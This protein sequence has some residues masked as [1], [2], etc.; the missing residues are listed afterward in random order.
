MPKLGYYPPPYPEE[1]IQGS[2]SRL[3]AHLGI[4]G[5][6]QTEVLFQGQNLKVSIDTVYN[7]SHFIKLLPK[8]TF[9]NVEE[10]IFQ[11]SLFPFYAPFLP[12]ESAQD[13]LIWTQNNPDHER[14]WGISKLIRP[15]A[16]PSMMRYCPI[17]VQEHREEYGE[18][19]WHRLHQ[20]PG[21][22]ICLK[23]LVFL[24]NSIVPRAASLRNFV[25]PAAELVIDQNYNADSVQPS[26]KIHRIMLQ[27]V[28]DITWL[29]NQRNVYHEL[30]ELESRCRNLLTQSGYRGSR[31]IR[32][33]VSEMRSFVP[34]EIFIK[35]GIKT[36]A[37][38]DEVLYLFFNQ[39]GK[40]PKSPILFF[41]FMQF[42]D[43]S[44]ETFFSEKT[45]RFEPFG[46]GPWPCL[47]P[48]CPDYGL[49][50]IDEVFFRFERQ[51]KPGPTG[52][53]LC[54][55]GFM[56]NCETLPVFPFDRKL[57]RVVICGLKWEETLRY[58]WD[59]PEMSLKDISKYMKM[60]P[61]ALGKHA[62]RLGLDFNRKY[63]PLK[64]GKVT[65]VTYGQHSA[66]IHINMRTKFMEALAERPTVENIENIIPEVYSWLYLHDYQWL[67]EKY[68][69]TSPS[70]DQ[71]IWDQRAIEYKEKAQ[72]AIQHILDADIWEKPIRR[73]TLNSIQVTIKKLYGYSIQINPNL[74]KMLLL[75][76]YLSTVLETDL[77]FTLRKLT[78]NKK[79]C[80]DKGVSI[81]Y[82]T[83]IA[84]AKI[85]DAMLDNSEVQAQ[86]IAA[87]QEI[88]QAVKHG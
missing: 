28:R 5:T 25:V 61:G 56:Y 82:I 11:H 47:N 3:Y 34:D 6:Q 59:L 88:R 15:F 38:I 17:C 30:S 40:D 53:F 29:I 77:Q 26:N 72:I 20:T 70:L 64:P 80:I 84:T 23:H 46:K 79:R 7:L 2:N 19:F 39:M 74:D 9:D 10:I 44:S 76:N 75:K 27:L 45:L 21:V 66:L 60:S 31:Y 24:R 55:C 78:I 85:K 14:I 71:E 48:I 81:G 51:H 73:V 4:S 18:T 86:I 42:L 41:L 33:L 57:Y 63:A 1:L 49:S 69:K 87:L 52:Y 37:T 50:V 54:H 83:F 67:Q 16:M 36:A 58:L 65:L 22:L 12:K 35:L 43:T 62:M 8:G 32:R 13:L 68:P